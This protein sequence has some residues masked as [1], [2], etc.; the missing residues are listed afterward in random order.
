MAIIISASPSLQELA[1]CSS[2]YEASIPPGMHFYWVR[3]QKQGKPCLLIIVSKL[4][5]ALLEVFSRHFLVSSFSV[6]WETTR[7]SVVSMIILASLVSL[8][9]AEYRGD[10]VA[11]RLRSFNVWS[12]FFFSSFCSQIFTI[13]F[14]F[15]SFVLGLW[16]WDFMFLN[17][18]TKLL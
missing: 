10:M 3:K 1:S 12:F 4:F 18:Q 15:W 14:P 8:S 13:N 11:S 17:L 2:P 9:C 16:K 7:N 6:Y 5:N